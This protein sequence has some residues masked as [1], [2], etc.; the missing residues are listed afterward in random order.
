M[1]PSLDHLV[2]FAVVTAT[3][4]LLLVSF[5]V[6]QTARRRRSVEWA[7]Y[8]L[9]LISVASFFNF[10][11]GEVRR[12]GRHVH[13]HE[14]FHFYLGS[15]YLPEVRYD[16]LYDATLV[17]AKES[18]W[19]EQPH[20]RRRDLS[21]FRMVSDLLPA[22]RRDEIRERFSPERWRQFRRDASLFFLHHRP[23]AYVKD[24]GNTGSPAWA[25]VAG[26]FTRSLEW[27]PTSAFVLGCLD[28]I[29]LLLLFA[30]VGWIFG[31]RVAA[32]T[33][34]V[35]LSV[36]LVY[37]YL[38]GSILRMDWIFALGMSV[39]L[40]ERG[41]YRGAGIFL[42]YA[43]AS[44]PFAA[45]VVVPLGFRLLADA[46]RERQVDRGRLRYVGYAILGLVLAVLLSSLYFGDAKLWDDYAERVTKT[47]HA[48]YY[49]NNHSLRDVF[50]QVVHEPAS[51][52]D[53]L[54][55]SVATRDPT[56]SVQDVRGGLLA[57]QLLCIAAL[58]IVA[59]RN[60]VRVA[61]ALG[62]L[63][64]FVLLVT[65]RYY[66]QVWMISAVALAPTYRR[67]WRHAAFLGGILVWLAAGHGLR[68]SSLGLD[69]EFGGY[70]GSFNLTLLGAAV[71]GLEAISW[72]RQGGSLLR[73]TQSSACGGSS[74]GRRRS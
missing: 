34:I 43:I 35:G 3:L 27:G 48:D 40:F 22:E 23:G 64:L 36:P 19:P 20:L 29:L 2:E 12:Q 10:G 8:V 37:T 16:G 46:I 24:H 65:N 11:L 17:A 72:C 49:R 13:Y 21:E 47:F 15:K 39:C 70:F 26:W 1:D 30:T 32:L 33:A 69:R 5:F 52:L 55:E 38:G 44:K 4:C 9:G 61:F 14:Q 50:L 28:L 60:P 71:V 68:F 74:A 73:V 18:H 53:P 63:A 6:E 42:G 41:S 56:V 45:V 7:F 51:A 62:P 57:A 58:G 25:M 59:I 67:D 54:P 31:A 66:W